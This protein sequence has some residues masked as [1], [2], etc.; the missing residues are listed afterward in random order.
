MKNNLKSVLAIVKELKYLL[1]KKYKRQLLGVMILIVLGSFLELLGVYAI[2]PFI[3]AILEPDK[4]MENIFIS[5]FV[6]FLG[7]ETT[8]GTLVLTGIL[9]IVLY[10]IKNLFMIF[11]GF[12]QCGFSTT[13]QKELSIK[14]LASYMRHPYMYFLNVNSSVI[15]RSCT[16]DVTG[17]YN[18]INNAVTIITETLNMIIIG[19]FL[20]YTDVFISIGVLV[21]MIITLAGF[22]FGLKPIIKRYGEKNV[23]AQTLMNKTILQAVHGLKEI[24]VMQRKKEFVAEY[25]HASEIYRKVRRNYD[26]INMCPDRIV[27]GICISGIIGVVCIRLSMGMDMLA[28]VPKLGIFA[29]AAFKLFPSIGKIV[30]RI[31]MVI[32]SRPLLH[33]CYENVAEAERY[34]KLVQEYSKE[35][36]KRPDDNSKKEFCSKLEVKHVQWQYPGQANPT[37]LDANMVIYKGESVAFI[38]E[39]GAGKTTLSDCI[40]GLL[41]P[42]SGSIEMDGID[43]YTMPVQ[44]G[45]IVGYVPQAV[46]LTDDTVRNNIAFGL[47]VKDDA[48][49]WSALDRAQLKRFVESL[50]EGLD[51]LVG[52]RGIKFSGG[53]K[54]RLAIARALYNKPEILILDEATAALDNDTEAAVME[55]IDA[56]QG[57]VTMIIVA[58]RLSTI[59]NCDKIFEIKDGQVITRKKEE[60]LS[61]N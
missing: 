51:T 9:I 41:K 61:V 1:G 35:H 15:L 6:A 28:F 16:S 57:Q 8:K 47:E 30:N 34:S 43:V 23:Y 11:S 38:G 37:L 19:V 7:I 25:E 36:E 27:E 10:I 13:V 5:R 26:F 45:E 20:I 29:M 4:L 22:I 3:E 49:I 56:L 14:M 40:L 55:S 53:Q 18:I 21:L 58:H 24:F 12:V 48:K 2:M 33:N 17:V 50:P 42:Q 46:F 31:N 39:S 60:V 44:W 32:F 59:R 54:Q 52:E